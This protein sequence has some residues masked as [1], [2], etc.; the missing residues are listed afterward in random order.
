MILPGSSVWFGHRI[1]YANELGEHRNREFNSNTA[2]FLRCR[3][4]GGTSSFSFS[5][6]WFLQ[7]QGDV[8][9]FQKPAAVWRASVMVFPCA[10]TSWTFEAVSGRNPKAVRRRFSPSRPSLAYTLILN[11]NSWKK[12]ILHGAGSMYWR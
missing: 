6:N 10:F 7:P 2:L 5:W 12:R 3:E 11:Q 9:Q 4:S 1:G 8:C